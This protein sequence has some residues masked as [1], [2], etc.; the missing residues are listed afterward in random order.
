VVYYSYQGLKTTTG[1]TEKWAIGRYARVI[2][3]NMEDKIRKTLAEVQKVLDDNG[4][5][6]RVKPEYN[7]HILPKEVKPEV[8][9]ETNDDSK[10]PEVSA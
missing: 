8:I 10:E 4:M 1:I 3:K 9:K 6:M 2:N 5:V 7:I